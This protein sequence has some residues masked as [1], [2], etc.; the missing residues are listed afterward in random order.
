MQGCS[1]KFE[2][3][4]STRLIENSLQSIALETSWLTDWHGKRGAKDLFLWM[5]IALAIF[6]RVYW[7]LKSL[8]QIELQKTSFEVFLTNFSPIPVSKLVLSLTQYLTGKRCKLNVYLPIFLSKNQTISIRTGNFS[9]LH[10][11]NHTWLV[12]D[13]ILFFTGKPVSKSSTLVKVPDP[14]QI[15]PTGRLTSWNIFLQNGTIF[16]QH[17]F[18]VKIIFSDFLKY[19]F[20]SVTFV[21]KIVGF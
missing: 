17:W 12:H 5:R 8:F 15:Q 14:G 10:S 2:A 4:F 20:F 6:Q 19:E 9:C 3:H 11:K 18:S 13:W 21:T 16:R 7:A 1:L